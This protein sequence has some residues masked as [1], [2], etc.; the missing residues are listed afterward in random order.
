MIAAFI[1]FEEGKFRTED[2]LPALEHL[3]GQLFGK[4]GNFKRN[5]EDFRNETERKGTLADEQDE[6]FNITQIDSLKA[7]LIEQFRLDL[8]KLLKDNQNKVVIYLD[9]LEKAPFQVLKCI[10]S[11]VLIHAIRTDN[12]FL[13]TAGQKPHEWMSSDIRSKSHRNVLKP[14]NMNITRKFIRALTRRNPYVTDFE[15]Y[16]IEKTFSLTSGH[17][18][19]TFKFI[20]YIFER[21]DELTIKETVDIQ[22][23]RGVESLVS[24]IVEQ[25]WKNLTMRQDYPPIEKTLLLISPLR[26]IEYG[27]F[28]FM[29]TNFMGGDIEE[30]SP[31]YFQTL[32][33]ELLDKTYLFVSRGLGGGYDMEK[34]VR[35]ILLVHLKV[36]N[37]KLYLDI[38]QTLAEKYDF[39][40]ATSTD[41]SQ[42]RH[43]I[44]RLYHLIMANKSDLTVYLDEIAQKQLRSYLHTYFTLTNLESMTVVIEQ[45]NRLKSELA[46]DEE[47]G[48]MI[49]VRQLIDCIDS[50][51]SSIVMNP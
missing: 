2:I 5:L 39:W 30:N 13:I 34:V 43:M 35:N 19:F 9:S 42:I 7:T 40:V 50:H 6:K 20:E 51:L 4:T 49:D 23:P 32:L 11:G 15:N 31:Y 33:G 14:F 21:D 29:L 28:H 27:T 16:L 44:E 25:V 38:Q 3:S 18:Y 41:M 37:E 47:L 26:R 1:D 48:D 17:P 22:F 46:T 8:N 36:N 45:C 24:L 12:F 10:E